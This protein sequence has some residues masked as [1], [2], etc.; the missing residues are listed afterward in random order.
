MR[1]FP[2]SPSQPSDAGPKTCR[3]EKVLSNS[4]RET[5]RESQ[6]W[7]SREDAPKLSDPSSRPLSPPL[8]TARFEG[9]KSTPKNL[10]IPAK[11]PFRSRREPRKPQISLAAP[12]GKNRETGENPKKSRQISLVAPPPAMR[13]SARNRRPKTS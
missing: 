6:S 11:T 5:R 3:I 2:Q 12:E 10:N 1:I 8:Q 4:T 13:Q 9:K 7:R